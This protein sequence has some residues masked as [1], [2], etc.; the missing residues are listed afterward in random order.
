MTKRLQKISSYI[1]EE[2]KIIDIGCDHAYLSEIL[3]KRKIYS[4]ASDLR[5]NIIEKASKRI[6]ED[7]KKYITFKVGDGITLKED[8]L[9]YIPVLAGM[10]SHLILDIISKSKI[11]FKKIIT[12]SNNN[13]DILRKEML[14]L[15]YKI[16]LEEIILEKNKYYNLIIF[17]PGSAIYNI[18][19]ITIG[20]NHQNIFLLKE[21]NKKLIE[22]YNKILKNIQKEK[23]KKKL[24]SI[25]KILSN[26]NY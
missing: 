23:D 9:D 15:G 24:E 6:G 1:N 3:A 16:E 11:K 26:F 18:E 20:V 4:I 5:S 14:K 2:E 25:I 19:E 10:G 8:E 7:L 13:H 22:K 21:K 17:K 12:I